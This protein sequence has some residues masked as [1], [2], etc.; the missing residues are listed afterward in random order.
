MTN[1]ISYHNVTVLQ[2]QNNKLGLHQASMV[3]CDNGDCGDS[4]FTIDITGD[5]NRLNTFPLEFSVFIL[6]FVLIVTG[7]L[8]RDLQLLTNV[9]AIII[10]VMGVFTLY[11]GYAQLNFSTLMGKVVGFG[12][13]G[14]GFYFM[15]EQVF[16]KDRQVETYDQHDDGRVHDLWFWLIWKEVIVSNG[17]IVSVAY[18]GT[19]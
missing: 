4:T 5:G 15:I 18:L 16:S 14:A 11:P 9:G 17:I 8:K 7:K 1:N 10:F 13:I 6:G 2:S 3:C 12:G 19:I